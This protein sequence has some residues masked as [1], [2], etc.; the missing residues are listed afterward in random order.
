MDSFSELTARLY[1]D[2]ILKQRYMYIID[3]LKNTLIITAGALLLGVI[4]GVLVALVRTTKTNKPKRFKWMFKVLNWICGLYL[5]V[6]RGTPIVI[7]LMLMYFAIWTTGSPIMVAIVAFGINSGAYVAEVMRSG[8]QSI[9]RGQVEASRSLGLNQTQTMLRIV[10]P[11]AIKN[12][13]PAIFNEFIVLL[14]ETSIAGYVGIHDLTKGGDIIRSITY[15]AFPPLIA[16]ACI[17][18]VIVIGLTS[19]LKH[20]ERRL[21][22]SDQR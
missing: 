9:P 17:Y 19:I 16:V 11:Q 12:M 6:I 14:K 22:V 21:A 20:M 18:L 13:A 4:L 7:Q 1:D 10:L 5:T 2:F 8:I 15:D 3:G